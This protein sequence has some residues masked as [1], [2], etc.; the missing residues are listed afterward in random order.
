MSKSLKNNLK[1]TLLVSA[2]LLMSHQAMA[3]FSLSGTRFIYEEG[4]KNISFE[5]SNGAKETY[6]GQV[7]VD[8]T[9]QNKDDVYIVP[10]PPFFKVKPEQKQIIRLINVNQSLPKAH[11]SLFWLN[12]QEVP[13]KPT[14]TEGSIL[15]IAMN[16]QVKLL[17]RPKAIIDGRKDAEK[18]IRIV[19]KGGQTLLKNPTPYYFAVVGIKHSDKEVKLSEKTQNALAQLA[20]YSEVNLGTEVQGNVSVDAINDWGGVQSYEV[21]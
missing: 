3:A 17:Y 12:V 4:K 7:W 18:K 8:N 9:T 1:K 15:A 16:T 20:P 5:V 6:G 21:K 2:V 11:E 14:Q 19:Q 10:S 13:P